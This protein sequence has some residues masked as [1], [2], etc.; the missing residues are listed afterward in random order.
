MNY[1]AAIIGAGWAGFNAAI[2]ARAAGLKVILI[3]RGPVGGTCLN[4]GCIPTKALIQSAKSYALV[5]K[6]PLFGIESQS[7][8]LNFGAAQARKDKITAGLRQ[9]MSFMLKGID[10]LQAQARIIDP[11][12]LAAGDQ[13][14]SVKHIL[15]ATGSRP[16][17]LS[18]LPFDGTRVISSDD[19]LMLQEI[20][21]AMLIVGGGVIGCEFASLFNILG[22]KVSV[23]E[24]MPQLL[25]GQDK[26]I[27]RKIESIFKKKGIT[28]STGTDASVFKPGEFDKIMVCVGRAPDTRGLGLEECGVTLERGRIVVDE[29]LRTSRQ[30]IYAAGDCASG[31]MLAHYAAYQGRVAAHNMAHPESPVKADNGVVPGCI[32]TDPEIAGVGLDEEAA[33]AKGM[34]VAVHKFDFL[35]SGMARI[36][37][38]AE[39]FIKIISQGPS[40]R[41]LGGHIIGP[42]ATELIATLTLAVSSGLSVRQLRE[43]IFAHPTVSEAIGDAVGG[44]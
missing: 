10:F 25:P 15:I 1:D 28:V 40:G 31:I 41:V 13:S 6:S 23:C 27:A 8:V 38:E 20:P 5:K 21:A 36:L 32:F 4:R 9:G 35:G 29:Y 16:Q 18:S 19:A 33:R 22:T 14:I 11:L 26:E 17:E 34:D 39:G 2:A 30:S 42:R 24:K 12:T 37:D 3:E 44:A 43:T 7:P